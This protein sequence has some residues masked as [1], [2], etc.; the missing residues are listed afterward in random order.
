M[1][2]LEFLIDAHDKAVNPHRPKT[3][4]SEKLGDLEDIGNFMNK[5][6]LEM[7]DN[8]NIFDQKK[9]I[10]ISAS[11]KKRYNAFA[12][13]KDHMPYV[14]FLEYYKIKPNWERHI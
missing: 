1:E 2:E 6:F 3:P 10:E 11:E 12:I 8:I 5:G 7:A 14:K 9:S 4:E 13:N